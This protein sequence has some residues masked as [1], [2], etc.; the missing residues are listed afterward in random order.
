[1]SRVILFPDSG[2]IRSRDSMTRQ[3]IL[4]STLIAVRLTIQRIFLYTAGRG[5]PLSPA[6]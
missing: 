5:R 4:N 2:R 1:M 6:D 3:D